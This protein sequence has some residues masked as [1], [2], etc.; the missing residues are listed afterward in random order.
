MPFPALAAGC[1]DHR[2]FASEELM[3]ASPEGSPEES[4]AL[5]LERAG[6]TVLGAPDEAGLPT[7][8][9]VWKSVAGFLVEPDATVPVSAPDWAEQV[10]ARW[11][12]LAR[13]SGLIA[14]DGTFLIHVG[15]RGLGR[16]GWAVVRWSD[17][18]RLAATLT[19]G[20]Q[21]PEF[22]TMARDAHTSCGV[23]TEEYD[24]WLVR[25][26]DGARGVDPQA[27]SGS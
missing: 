3:S 9:E 19:D 15:G 2:L 7:P 16:L 12:E 17:G 14:P 8:G 24:I 25:T 18:A 11:L 22:V 13:D 1:G 21:Q 27:P 20:P 4:R 6:L 5:L 10:D 26:D 23:T